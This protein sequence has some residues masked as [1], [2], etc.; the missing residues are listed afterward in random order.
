MPIPHLK[1]ND[2][3]AATLLGIM[4]EYWVFIAGK[5]RRVAM[6]VYIDFSYSL[7]TEGLKTT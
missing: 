2:G 4:N 7:S 3:E 6:C 1:E 5:R